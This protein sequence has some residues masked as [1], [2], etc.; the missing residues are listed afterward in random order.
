MTQFQNNDEKVLADLIKSATKFELNPEE[1][2]GMYL[3][4]REYARM[5]PIRIRHAPR[6]APKNWFMFGARP[7]PTMAAVMIVVLSTGTAFA[8]EN[9]LPGDFLY[10]IKV[11]VNEPVISALSVSTEAKASWAIERAERRIEEAASLALSGTLDEETSEELNVRLEE[12]VAEAEA[13]QAEME[14]TDTLAAARIETNLRAA[15][16]AHADVLADVRAEVEDE[17]TQARIDTVIE[18]V[19]TRTFA[20][21]RMQKRDTETASMMALDISIDAAEESDTDEDVEESRN[22]ARKRIDASERL[23]VRNES[24]VGGDTRSR[25]RARLTDAKSVFAEAENSLSRGDKKGANSQFNRAL[26]GAIETR[27]LLAT[28]ANNNSKELK[29]GSSDASTTS[30][31]IETPASGSGT[32][33]VTISA[34]TAATSAATTSKKADADEDD[35]DEDDDEIKVEVEIKSDEDNDSHN[36]KGKI[37]IDL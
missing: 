21:A 27:A 23:V 1:K 15:L 37:H 34:S 14:K 8:A 36:S 18:H 30:I 22:I 26:H 3:M 13:E 31:V 29:K 2:K 9:A 24:R 16:L 10:D 6:R 28:R 12:H 25:L 19:S 11:S 20:S 33:T 32:A 5:K 7:M 4:L 35:D 17:E